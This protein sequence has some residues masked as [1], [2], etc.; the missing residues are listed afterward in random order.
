MC[1]HNSF[2]SWLPRLF[3]PPQV[4]KKLWKWLP[5]AEK[6]NLKHLCLIH[7]V[8]LAPFLA[9]NAVCNWE[10][11]SQLPENEYKKKV[12]VA[13]HFSASSPIP[14]RIQKAEH[15]YNVNIPAHT[16]DIR[17]RSCWCRQL[18]ITEFRLATL[19]NV[20][21]LKRHTMLFYY[22]EAQKQNVSFHF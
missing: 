15:S 4:N 19:M 21:T 7:L 14:D 1:Q 17:N 12:F 5:K 9:I 8:R 3:F 2:L 16:A 10:H 11:P 6:S 13:L 22:H 20:Y 18:Q